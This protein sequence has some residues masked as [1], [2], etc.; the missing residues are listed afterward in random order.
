MY[1]NIVLSQTEPAFF[2]RWTWNSRCWLLTA[3]FNCLYRNRWSYLSHIQSIMKR[4]E[5][6]LQ[7]VS[8]C[9]GHLAQV[10]TLNLSVLPALFLSSNR[11][12]IILKST[13]PQH[14]SSQHAE[15]ACR[16]TFKLNLEAWA[17]IWYCN[18]A[19]QQTINH[20]SC[21][22]FWA[23]PDSAFYTDTHTQTQNNNH[24]TMLFFNIT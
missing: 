23:P 5:L 14:A 15:A 13:L 2:Y 24:F 3:S 6:S 12:W 21:G 16:W 18:A 4:W 1:Y 8:S 9:M 7:K 10:R 22:V 17:A 11:R 19:N 20:S